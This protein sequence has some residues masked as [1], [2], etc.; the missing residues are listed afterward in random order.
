MEDTVLT[1]KHL[2]NALSEAAESDIQKTL[3]P[4]QIH[5]K[6]DI[7]HLINAILEAQVGQQW[8]W[9]Q[10]STSQSRT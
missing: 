8:I 4:W 3:Y 10:A 6:Q 1:A 2:C 5:G 7:G 9:R